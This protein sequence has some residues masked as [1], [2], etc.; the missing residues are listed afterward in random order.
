MLIALPVDQIAYWLFVCASCVPAAG[1]LAFA[2]ASLRREVA[3]GG[4]G[5]MKVSQAIASAGFEHLNDFFIRNE[6]G[7]LTQIDHAVRMP[8]GILVVETKDWSGNFEYP[9]ERHGRPWNRI[10]DEGGL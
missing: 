3:P 10:D 6:H 5:E 4:A 2:F 1:L 9:I 7:G 8:G